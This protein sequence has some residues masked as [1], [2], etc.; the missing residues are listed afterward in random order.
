VVVGLEGVAEPVDVVIDMVGGPQMVAAY[1]LLAPGGSL[2]SIG[3]ASGESAVFPPGST[4]G[5][6]TPI[7][8]TS[9]YNGSGPSDRHKQ[10]KAL[11]DLTAAGSL[12]PAV[13]WRGSWEQ[14]A[15]AAE[16][17]TSRSLWGKAILDITRR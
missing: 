3:W 10:L 15:E 6:K 16:A 4:L 12:K 13:G 8:I 1:G 14:I 7:S 11:L 2:Q 17:L 9:V 5:R